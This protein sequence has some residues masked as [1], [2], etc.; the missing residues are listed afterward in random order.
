MSFTSVCFPGGMRW[1][2]PLLLPAL[3]LPALGASGCADAGIGLAAGG[4]ASVAVLGRT[5]IDVGVSLATGKDCSVV[6]LDRGQTYCAPQ[7]AAVT[8]PP[9]CSRSLG[10]VD[11]WANPEAFVNRPAEVADQPKPTPA[12]ERYRTAP[13]PKSLTAGS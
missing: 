1:S 4:I 9:Y 7:E 11:C 5:P 3:L 2:L 8:R 10:T 13:W 12:Q 6:R